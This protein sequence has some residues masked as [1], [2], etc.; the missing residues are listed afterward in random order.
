MTCATLRNP[1]PRIWADDPLTGRRRN[2][3]EEEEHAF[4]AWALIEILRH[5]GIRIEELTELS[6]HSLIRY[7]LPGDGQPVPLLHIAPSKTVGRRALETG[8]GQPITRP[9]CC[10]ARQRDATTGV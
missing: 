9:I 10:A 3:T 8:S 1:S 7:E 4:W 2:L 5:T 6:H